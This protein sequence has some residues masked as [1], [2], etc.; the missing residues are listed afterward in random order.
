MKLTVFLGALSFPV[1]GVAAD[2]D[3]WPTQHTFADGTTLRATGHFAYDAY[4]FSGD[5]A[6][7]D[8]DG[9]R[10]EEFG[11]AIGKKGVY[12]AIVYYEFKAKAWLDVFVRVDTQALFSQD[13]GKLR[14]GY[15]R[16]PVGL[17]NLTASRAL[18]FLETAAPM[19]ASYQG[20]RTG[21]DW[22]LE[23]PTFLINTG[24]YFGK[25]LQG[26][27]HGTTFALRG[28]WTP[29]KS[30]GKV[31]HLGFSGAVENPRGHTDG[32]GE[33][34]PATARLRSRPETGLDT[35]RLV[36]SGPLKDT[37]HVR[38]IDLEALWIR[39]PWSLQSELTRM[40][41]KRRGLLPDA[42]LQGYYIFAS[43][44]LTG[45]SRPYANGL[46]SAIKPAHAYGALEVLLRRSSLDL[47]HGQIRGG[48]QDNWT[49]G[50][51]WYLTS[52]F[53]LQTQ[54]VRVDARR[55]GIQHNPD[56]LQLRAQVY[57]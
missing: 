54:Y 22:A 4:R 11:V 6:L 52:H 35:P 12:D 56:I 31:L 5:E 7:K 26:R 46:P 47:D 29:Q 23:R 38:R 43:W 21:I 30:A 53:R 39:G 17:E 49:L 19:Q 45:E 14:L 9:M 50:V 40:K 32:R 1:A 25:D 41:V 44:V 8:A 3:R 37:Q 57:F 13:Y 42:S 10:R 18:S 34:I 24:Y 33:A 48:R 28:I 15:A 2:F 16:V 55:N 20:R 27:N 51:N 36:D